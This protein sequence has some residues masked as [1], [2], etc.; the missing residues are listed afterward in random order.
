[1]E[2]V[3]DPQGVDPTGG[4]LWV[5]TYGTIDVRALEP[6]IVI[7]RCA[8]SV[9][10][11]H[12][13]VRGGGTRIAGTR[14][15]TP[16][17]AVIEAQKGFFSG[18]V[19]SIEREGVKLPILVWEINGKAFLRYGASRVWAARQL[20][21]ETIPAV[22]CGYGPNLPGGF[23]FEGWCN[24]PAQVLLAFRNPRIVGHFECSH[25]MIDAHRMEP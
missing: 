3:Q 6:R 5:G 16:E 10:D 12:Y 24:T 9:G 15:L 13:R 20:D 21:L 25:E 4:K 7:A 17:K 1:M 18:L 22:L 23:E 14:P 19:N 2:S 11:L 8:A